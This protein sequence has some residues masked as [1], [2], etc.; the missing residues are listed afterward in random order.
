MFSPVKPRLSRSSLT[1]RHTPR[2]EAGVF[3][4]GYFEYARQDRTSIPYLSRRA[5]PQSRQTAMEHPPLSR[6]VRAMLRL[7]L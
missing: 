5:I 6:P 7:A 2:D 3:V 1:A 4:G